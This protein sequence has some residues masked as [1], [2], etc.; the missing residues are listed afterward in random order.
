MYDT[1]FKF[2]DATIFD[3]SGMNEL[4]VSMGDLTSESI[5]YPAMIFDG[6][7]STA[8][9]TKQVKGL[10]GEET[11]EEDAK[12]YLVDIVYKN[13]DVEFKSSRTTDG[14]VSTYDFD[15][16]VDDKEFDVQVSK[17]GCLLITVSSYAESADAII[18]K[19]QAVEISQNFANN[20]G[21]KNMHSVWAEEKFNVAYI[22]LAPI[23]NDVIMYPDL[24]KVKVDLT[25]QEVIGFEAVNYAFNHT[26]R[27][28]DFVL[29]EFEAETK[30]GFDYEIIST[31][32][33]V[34][35][36]DS[37]IE[38]S[39]YEFFV[40]RIDGKY[41]YYINAQNGEIAKVMKL[42]VLDDVE[43]II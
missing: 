6:P 14:D 41:F 37:G 4:S 5:D 13:R 27:N 43:K 24:V 23:E 11:T 28:F 34:I 39:A 12:K 32:K 33:T 42:V 40:E 9:E 38:I 20:I 16:E 15:I 21:F 18:S 17:V 22:N 1:G 8:L 19:E 30:L 26:E 35:K 10:K 29:N 2:V 25:S 36:L 7:F 31:S 3:D